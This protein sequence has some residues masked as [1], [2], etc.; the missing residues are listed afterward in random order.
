MTRLLSVLATR[1][2]IHLSTECVYP[3]IP[4]RN[5]DWC[6]VDDNT[7]DVDCDENGYFSHSPYGTGATESEAINDLL[8]QL[9]D[10]HA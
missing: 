10:T 1:E 5:L 6:A 8:D 9:E 4:I 7:Y 2:V 3:P